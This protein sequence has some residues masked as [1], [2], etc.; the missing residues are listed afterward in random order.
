ML[1]GLLVLSI[2]STVCYSQLTVGRIVG[3]VTDASG[4]AIVDTVVNAQELASGA[5]IQ[6]TTSQ[7]GSYVFTSL[8]PGTYT[9]AVE[10]QGFTRIEQSGIVLDAASTR[11]VDLVLRPGSAT[12]SVSVIANAEAVKVDSGEVSQTLDTRKLDQVAMNG[13]NYYNLLN[14]LPGVT[15][16]SLDPVAVG[17]NMTGTFINGSRNPSTGVFVDGVNNISND[18]NSYQTIVPNPDTIG[19]VKVLTS[20]YAA[21]Y[22]GNAG[23][24]ITLI[25]KSGG[26]DFHGS[27]FEYFR[28]DKFDAR[29]FLAAVKE[30]LHLNDFGATLGG[31]IFIP[32]KLNAA[33]NKLFFFTAFEKKYYHTNA[34]SV[35]IVPTA[36][37]RAGNFVGSKLAA[38]IDPT[39][40][41]PFP[42][43]IVPSPRW[44]P[45]GPGLLA[46]YPLPNANSAA[47]N[48]IRNGL[49]AQE[50]LSFQVKPEYYAS[51]KLRIT[52]SYAMNSNF[53]WNNGGALGVLP[54]V[55]GSG[56]PGWISGANVNYTFSPT[57]LNYFSFGVTHQNFKWEP[58]SPNLNRDL[59]NLTFQQLPTLNTFN[60]RPKISMTGLTGLSWANPSKMNTTF[61]FHDDLTKTFGGHILKFGVM[62]SRSRDDE[63]TTGFT[64]VAGSL[65]FN[66]SATNT[67]KNPIADALLGNFYQYTQDEYA[68]FGW[69]RF[70]T[71]EA[72]A[73]D[74]WRV[75][76]HLH[77]DLGV[78]YSFDELPYTPVGNASVFFPSI[79]NPAQAVKVDRTSGA[80]V[81]GAGNPYDGLALVGQGWSDYP[82][83]D[84]IP[85][86]VANGNLNNLNSLFIDRPRTIWNNRK[87]DFAPRIGFAYDLTGDGM[88]ALRG[89]FG[90]FYDRPAANIYLLSMALNSPFDFAYNVFNGN[91]DNIAAANNA[92]YPANLT[93]VSENFKTPYTMTYNLDVQRQ[94]PF[95]LILDVGY[96]GTQAR[97]LARG[98]NLNQLPVGTLTKP[99]NVGANANSLRPYPGYGN[100]TDYDYGD[101]SS[102]NGLQ[103]SATRRMAS[104][105]SFGSAFTW[106]KATDY[107]AAQSGFTP[108][109]V[110]DSY[111]AK[112]DHSASSVNRKF[113]F[114]INSQYELPLAKKQHGALHAIAGGWILSPVLFAQ[115]GAPTSVTVASDVAGIGSASSRASLVPNADLSVS[116]RSFT[117][118]FNTAAFLPVSQMTQGQFGNSGRNILTGPGFY[119][120]DVSLFKEFSLH[121]HTQLEF[122]AESFNI[123]NHA[124]PIA[125]GTT[126]GT[127]TFGV[128]TSTG[129]PRIDQFALKL[130]F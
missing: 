117:Q 11:T 95:K 103:V 37:E 38:P 72:Y 31:P 53:T 127:S 97:H 111:N 112:A 45:N 118:W 60:S 28:N 36:L 74:S 44:S 62:L 22:G 125:V 56:Q 55:R 14:L 23:A 20:S 89:G 4:A 24:M 105:L 61:E 66:S 17:V 10:K 100:I 42:G 16:S 102:Y 114:S 51:D 13:R 101:T 115:S 50:P 76:R 32:G 109:T 130:R 98:L 9:L 110:Q 73:Q 119:E 57:L 41:A 33:K 12:E 78:R 86:I 121:E 94:L 106:S 48:F 124:C 30:P 43:A 91:I 3:I 128:V 81:A 58:P 21:E 71:F 116:N 80:I 107:L 1:R 19:E 68:V 6:A 104:G 82:K 84:R 108:G 18:Q 26:R 120:L 90:M 93:T 52:T 65:T 54:S 8:P 49:S 15:T 67:T 85:A 29:S 96:V 75:S 39:N 129:N 34:A 63:N 99:Q 40:H 2:F 46:I 5:K 77:L 70:S 79:W 69:S 87:N 27:G 25:S 59:W 92:S 113:V 47:G 122:R 35:S 83:H 123:M 126:V 64:N 88:T 7:N